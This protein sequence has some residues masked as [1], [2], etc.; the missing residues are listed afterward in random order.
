MGGFRSNLF[1]GTAGSPQLQLPDNL[2]DDTIASTSATENR[3]IRQQFLEAAS[4]EETRHLVK[5]LYRENATIGDGG[6]ADAIRIQLSTG[7]LVGG[8]D[9]T[10]KGRERLRQIEKLLSRFPN[11]PD[12][13]LLEQL[14][15]DLKDALG[16]A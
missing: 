5:E 12:R 2:A 15:D 6:T 14:R 4:T 3:A 9:H 10:R 11:H 16:G 8:K 1:H 13:N 7:E